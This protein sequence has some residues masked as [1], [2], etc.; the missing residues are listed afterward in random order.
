MRYTVLWLLTKSVQSN[1]GHYLC[2]FTRQNQLEPI[3]FYSTL[4]GRSCRVNNCLQAILTFFDDLSPTNIDY[5]EK[6]LPLCYEVL[7]LLCTNNSSNI[8]KIT[9]DTLHEHLFI[10]KQIQLFFPLKT[11][12][13]NIFKYS[14]ETY[15]LRLITHEL[16]HLTN[17]PTIISKNLI[18][19]T[20]NLLFELID[21]K[22]NRL[23]LSLLN[24]PFI[25]QDYLLI[26]QLKTPN[27]DLN[28]INHI[29]QACQYNERT[30]LKLYRLDSL[31][32]FLSNEIKTIQQ[33]STS[34]NNNNELINEI[35]NNQDNYIYDCKIILA[36]ANHLNN[37]QIDFYWRNSHIDA[38]R[39]L[40][41]LILYLNLNQIKTFPFDLCNFLYEKIFNQ[42][43]IIFD[44][45]Q[46]SHLMN[47]FLTSTISIKQLKITGEYRMNLIIILK[48]L[49]DFIQ[50]RFTSKGRAAIYGAIV[51]CIEII[52]HIEQQQQ[53][54]DLRKIFN[55]AIQHNH[56]L[57]TI[58]YNDA[59]SN[60]PAV[61]VSFYSLVLFI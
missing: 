45:Q 59:L 3:D 56:N 39:S 44:D 30:N 24:L 54:D 43:N 17:E 40:I 34:N 41:E 7:Y 8:I 50:Q 1:I 5:Y 53:Q 23:T 18:D 38:W 31:R 36:Y 49:F 15:L 16:F 9:F 37:E 11:S 61:R 2:G 55:N 47:I 57:L 13:T 28:K 29:L 25:K 6:S 10:Q 52:E 20:I 19:T 22:L 51:Q 33:T 4:T 12:L 27:I 21:I 46:S 35:N 60:V 32:K 48:N 14:I 58:I 42:T 26:N